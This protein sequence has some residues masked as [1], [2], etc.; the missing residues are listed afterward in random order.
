LTFGSDKTVAEL[1]EK[2]MST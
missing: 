2:V 1:R